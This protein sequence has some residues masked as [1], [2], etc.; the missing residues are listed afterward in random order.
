MDSSLCEVCK[1][2][3]KQPKFYRDCTFLL[4]NNL[5]YWY[6]RLH[7]RHKFHEAC[8]GPQSSKTKACPICHVKYTEYERVHFYSS[9]K[10]YF[11]V[12]N[13]QVPEIEND[14]KIC[15]ICLERW[16]QLKTNQN[17]IPNN[18]VR[19]VKHGCAAKLDCG[20]TYH[21]SC[22]S[23]WIKQSNTCQYCRHEWRNFLESY[24]LRLV[25]AKALE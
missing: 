2:E 23:E 24:H 6:V 21:S 14:D 3:L 25:T 8:L 19:S 9:W 5:H 15:T 10:Y 4:G 1:C 22:L 17:V 18:D 7:C 20:H 11:H 16:D 13:W 12:H